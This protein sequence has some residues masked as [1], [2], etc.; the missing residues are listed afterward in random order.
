MALTPVLSPALAADG[1]IPIS[2]C[3]LWT[4]APDDADVVSTPGVAAS[5]VVVFPSSPSA[6]S[7][8]TEFVMWGNVFEIQSGTDFTA[9]SFKVVPTD[10]AETINNFVGMVS[11]NY[12]FAIAVTV[13]VDYTTRTVT[14]T[15]NDCGKQPNFGS[16]QM[17]FADITGTAITSAT[18]TN[19][20]TPVYVDGYKFV[21][22]MLRT[23]I[24]NDANSGFVTAPEAMEPNKDC[25]GGGDVGFNGMPTARR[26]LKTEI[27]PLNNTHPAVTFDGPIQYFSLQYGW[28]YRDANANA[29]SGEFATTGRSSVW[30]AYF[31]PDDVYK[32]RRYWPGA[33]GGLPPGQL[34]VKMLTQQPNPHYLLKKS[35]AWMWYMVNDAVQTYTNIRMRVVV[36]KIG[37]GTL[38]STFIVP[39]SSF[40]IN[41]VNT[42]PSFIVS[43]GLSGVTIDNIDY[44]DCAIFKQ[45]SATPTDVTQIT[46]A[47]TFY[48][49]QVCD[50]D[51]HTDIYFLDKLGG[52]G[53]LPVEI[54]EETAS[55]TGDEILLDVPCSASR[56]DKAAYGGRTLSNIRSNMVLTLRAFHKGGE[57]YVNFFRSM[58]LS[59]QRWIR[60]TDET[61]AFIARK[62]IV[63]TGGVRVFQEGSRASL[64][65]SGYMG[66]IVIQSGS[67]PEI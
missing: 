32:V 37:G 33:T 13:G 51:Q 21:Y 26:L 1:P 9:N 27:P 7:N 35:K 57:G 53:T 66:D 8:G 55:Q 12:F 39:N 4:F 56:A 67:E 10:A 45:N 46:E 54:I 2:D 58:K 5:L 60:T 25:T 15:W 38:S 31:E 23:D 17:D 30:N 28:V 42:S 19:G 44:Y 29:R 6:P 18:P 43:L 3:L 59:P 41:A 62:F 63:D 16:E 65:V 14:L 52:I 50:S 61:G 22:R 24:V 11:A 20:T 47:H 40:G 64:E 34:H 48:V 49:M 36:Q